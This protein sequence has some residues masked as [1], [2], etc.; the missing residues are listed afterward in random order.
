MEENKDKIR[1]EEQEA[2]AASPVKPVTPPP[3]VR[4]QWTPPP[5]PPLPVYQT[6]REELIFGALLLLCNVFLWDCIVAGGFNLGFAL[7]AVCVI[8]CSVGYLLSR[9]CRPNLYSG[10]LL[11]LAAVIAGAFGRSADGF[12]KYVML[13]FLLLAVNLGLCLM[14]GQNRRNPG[15]FA[16][17]ADA[18]RALFVLG[19]GGMGATGRGLK[20][21][22]KNAGKFGKQ[23]TAVAAGLAVSVPVVILLVTLLMRAD[24][25]FEGLLD[26][27]PEADWQEY[28]LAAAFGTMSAWVLFSRGVALHRRNK[29]TQAQRG[30]KGL[31]PLTVN[32]VLIAA[33]L[34]YCAYLLSQLAYLSGGFAGILPEGYTMAEYARR[35][36]F[37]MA[38]LCAINLAVIGLAVGLIEKENRAPLL[39]RLLCLFLG[40][41][42]VFLVS[43]ASAKMFMYI[44]GYG[45]TRLRVLT[46]VIM[47]WL[48]LATVLVCLWL[49]LPK[50]PYMKAVVLPALVMGAGVIWT[51]VDTQ[52]ARY[53]VRAYQTGRLETV[54]VGH[55]ND[56]GPGAVPYLIEL[57]ED[58][59]PEIAEM[60]ADV[61]LDTYYEVEDFRDWNY[62]KAK[63]AG[64]LTALR[65]EESREIAA[66]LTEELG[67]AVPVGQ[68]QYRYGLDNL[69]EKGQTLRILELTET[70]HEEFVAALE[71][72]AG[73]EGPWHAM[74][75]ENPVRALLHGGMARV[76]RFW[77]D[78]STSILPPM[79]EGYW[80]FLDRHE[81]TE[82]P[83]DTEAF[84]TWDEYHFTLAVYHSE[85]RRIY[86]FT[87]DVPK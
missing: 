27:L 49:F 33:C 24:A 34:V 60:A 19:F 6:G 37:E 30:R 83:Y 51:D 20:E 72:A 23:T 10:S 7:G 56:L 1:P 52:V 46:E 65:E 8:G 11:I 55:L 21:A 87:M 41:I 80:F 16:S 14:A 22:R 18:P 79:E 63:T 32:T 73:E 54:D 42:T 86:C 45:L 59:D 25:A 71:A 67:I 13:H 48:G 53:N 26:Q 62:A 58:G 43:T 12:V 35:G 3:P 47:V 57:T 70:Q 84:L 9:G 28:F 76:P 29:E 68:V 81:L 85:A 77:D 36:F 31:H 38:W 78:Y 74:P 69:E 17:L 50:L 64:I 4:P 61:L 5:A 75:M 2:M 40:L 66:A 44:G 15:G 82:H 39:T